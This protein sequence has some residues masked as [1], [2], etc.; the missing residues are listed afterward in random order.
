MSIMNSL[1]M[2]ASN[3]V[4]DSLN[5]K[6]WLS[7][8]KVR[9]MISERSPIIHCL[10]EPDDSDETVHAVSAW[11]CHKNEPYVVIPVPKKHHEACYSGKVEDNQMLLMKLPIKAV[12]DVR[13]KY[14]EKLEA[15]NVSTPGKR[16]LRV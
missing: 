6:P 1:N 3:E 15:L 4:A 13:V 16:R 9:N 12:C 5:A 10:R 14:F 7:T 8:P 11:V 2:Y